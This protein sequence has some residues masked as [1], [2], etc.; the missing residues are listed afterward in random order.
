MNPGKFLIRIYMYIL[1]FFNYVATE[2]YCGS[3]EF[4]Y[5]G[6]SKNECSVVLEICP[7]PN[8][9]LNQ[10]DSVNKCTIDTRLDMCDANIQKHQFSYLPALQYCFE[11]LT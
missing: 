11:I 10:P 1:L 7:T 6:T 4:K 3:S 2:T 5:P 8:Q 9:T